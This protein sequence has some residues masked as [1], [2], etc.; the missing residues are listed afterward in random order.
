MKGL[1]RTGIK[2]AALGASVLM[3]GGCS[4]LFTNTNIGFPPA[5]Q[6][7]ADCAAG[8]PLACD[9]YNFLTGVCNG[10]IAIPITSGNID[11]A[12]CVG[13]GYRTVPTSSLKFSDNADL[14]NEQTAWLDNA[15]GD[16]AALIK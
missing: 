13:L 3:L 2:L 15:N 1:K 7:Q 16:D 11:Q 10:T 4:S 9:V 12:L 14:T 6:M 5:P 8:A